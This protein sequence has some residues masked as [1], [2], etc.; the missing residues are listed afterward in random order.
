[1]SHLT[2]IDKLGKDNFDTWKLQIEAVLIKNDH[3]NYVTGKEA[4]PAEGTDEEG[5][6]FQADQKARADIILAI[7]P[8]ELCH[9]KHCATSNEIWIKLK[10]VYESKGPAKKATLLKQ[11]LFRK[12]SANES[13]SDHLNIFFD[14]VDK[15]REMEINIADDLLSILLL[16]SVPDNFENFRCAIECRDE[17]PKPES[18]KIKML[19]EWEAR[20]GKISR[21]SQNAFYSENRKFYQ[22]QKKNEKWKVNEN[23]NFS[24]QKNYRNIKCN[25]CSKIGHVAS[26]CRKKIADRKAAPINKQ[27]NQGSMMATGCEEPKCLASTSNDTHQQSDSCV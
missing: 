10:E 27:G 16:Y 3:W 4:K 7:N 21:E 8:S 26:Y 5:K 19:E 22:E 23:K 6:W 25:Y 13:M 18:L 9:I 24:A 2:S 12:M 11:L 15:L 17:L 1:M 20:K 14:I